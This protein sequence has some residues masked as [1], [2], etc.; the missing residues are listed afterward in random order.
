ML[1]THEDYKGVPYFVLC[2][3]TCFGNR[4]Q[5]F[6][7]M[8]K[9]KEASPREMGCVLNFFIIG[10]PKMSL[11]KLTTGAQVYIAGFS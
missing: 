7:I 4:F 6:E 5:D 8:K 9:L 3:P 10:R 1:R 2:S 11:L